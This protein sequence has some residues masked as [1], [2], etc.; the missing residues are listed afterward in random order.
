[1]LEVT[2]REYYVTGT[3]SDQ[4]QGSETIFRENVG[5]TIRVYHR[6]ALGVQFVGSRRNAHYPGI[7]D[8]RQT[9]GTLRIVYTF[10]GETDFGAV[11]SY[12][13]QH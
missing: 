7:P 2:S 4:K 10:L 1:M 3:G 13:A 8:R 11:G 12:A 6:H 5:A 9:V